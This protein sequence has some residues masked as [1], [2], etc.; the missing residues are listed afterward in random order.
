VSYNSFLFVAFLVASHGL[1][2]FPVGP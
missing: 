2:H 1:S